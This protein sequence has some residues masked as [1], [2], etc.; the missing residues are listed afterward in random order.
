MNRGCK[1]EPGIY[2]TFSIWGGRG[3][4][5]NKCGTRKK[6]AFEA[7]GM[8]ICEG[9]VLLYFGV[10]RLRRR[11]VIHMFNIDVYRISDQLNTIRS[12]YE[13]NRVTLS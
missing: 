3:V 10:D 12:R 7:P 1:C 2:L 9:D 5:W 4:F 8:F 13:Y 11:V 6:K